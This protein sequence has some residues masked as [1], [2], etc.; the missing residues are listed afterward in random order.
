MES[1]AH[2][3]MVLMDVQKLISIILIKA[4]IIRTFMSGTRVGIE[5]IRGVR[6]LTHRHQS[7]NRG[8]NLLRCGMSKKFHEMRCFL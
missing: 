3:F 7:L 2:A 6:F 4:P 5:S 1:A 8:L